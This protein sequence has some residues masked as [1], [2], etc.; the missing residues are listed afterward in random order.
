MR[1]LVLALDGL[2]YDLVIKWRMR[3]LL[4]KKYGKIELGEEH[5]YMNL[6]P[7]TPIVWASF[8]TGL[9]PS[10]HKV[11]SLWTYGRV[12]DFIRE[13]P[14]ISWVKNKRK[15]LYKLG[16]LEPKIVRKE[17]LNAK[18]IFDVVKPSIAVRVITYNDDV[19]QWRRASKAM[20]FGGVKKYEEVLWENHREREKELFENLNKNWRLLMAYFRI[21]DEKGHIH[22]AKRPY[23]LK[24]VY[25]RLDMLA[26]K[27]RKQLP[28]DTILLIVSDHGMK[29]A[30]DGTGV[31]SHHAFWS[32]NID[33]DWKPKKI[34]D[35]FP[36][37]VRWCNAV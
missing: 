7:Y 5:Y 36:Q 13:L 32:I 17:N 8:I 33:T 15:I 23:I 6:E 21:A 34:T 24:R 10:R 37:I 16:I 12:L 18:T 20:L 1:V 11:R 3:N 22:I 14:V 19:E 9:P 25:R 26:Y 29:P 35:F 28:G 4:Q 30:P 31:H 27:V 2:E